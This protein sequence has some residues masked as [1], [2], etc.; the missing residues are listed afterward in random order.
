MGYNRE[1][2]SWNTDKG[3]P[4]IPD[5]QKLEQQNLWHTFIANAFHASLYLYLEALEKTWTAGK[6]GVLG[7]NPTG[8][9]N[10]DRYRQSRT[11]SPAINRSTR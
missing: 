1:V 5:A 8:G 3:D 2:L 10:D 6:D 7:V 4:I 9:L 11:I